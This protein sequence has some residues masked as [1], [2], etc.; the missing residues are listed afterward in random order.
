[1]IEQ[2]PQAIHIPQ[3]YFPDIQFKILLLLSHSS[4]IRLLSK[5]F[6]KQNF[7]LPPYQLEIQSL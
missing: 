2:N 4:S 3:I 1:M 5:T 7:I 6:L